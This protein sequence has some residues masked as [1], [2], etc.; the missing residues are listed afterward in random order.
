VGS[1]A[2]K[3]MDKATERMEKFGVC[4]VFISRAMIVADWPRL[5]RTC[6][7]EGPLSWGTVLQSVN[8]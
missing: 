5:L 3:A 2:P 7:D 4:M 8:F 6:L 1:K